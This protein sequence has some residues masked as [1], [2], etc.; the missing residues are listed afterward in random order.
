MNIENQ[1][2]WKDRK[3]AWERKRIMQSVSKTNRD[4]F[5][6]QLSYFTEDSRRN[7]IK[8]GKNTDS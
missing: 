2:F 5:N 8:W 3:R 1:F 4:G 6:S 7:D